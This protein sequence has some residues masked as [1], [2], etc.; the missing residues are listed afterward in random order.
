MEELN[1]IGKYFTPSVMMFVCVHCAELAREEKRAFKTEGENGLS[2][3]AIPSK[4][5]LAAA[6]DHD[7]AFFFLEF[8]LAGGLDPTRKG[9]FNGQLKKTDRI[10]SL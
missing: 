8:L 9:H 6:Q 10:D 3:R 4:A 5:I 1:I 2:C 7:H